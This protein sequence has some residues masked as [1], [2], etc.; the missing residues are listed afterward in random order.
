MLNSE[1]LPKKI[2]KFGIN[3]IH[4]AQCGGHGVAGAVGT[5]VYGTRE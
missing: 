4:S 2:I 3:L 1:K 5:A